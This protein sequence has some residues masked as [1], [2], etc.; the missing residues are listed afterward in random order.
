MLRGKFALKYEPENKNPITANK[1]TMN[2][3]AAALPI[4]LFIGYPKYL[5]TGTFITAPPMPIVDE[6]RPDIVPK[7][8]LGAKLKFAFILLVFF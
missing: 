1:A 5:K 6:I 3:I 8:I 2:P 4:A 7:I